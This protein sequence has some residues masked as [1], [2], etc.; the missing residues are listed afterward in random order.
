M[1]RC[2]AAHDLL[3]KTVQEKDVNII[4]GQEPNKSLCNRFIC[5]TNCDS[6]IYINRADAVIS[7]R[8]GSGYVF[9][10]LAS[11][12]VCSFYFSPN[13]DAAKFEELLS[14]VNAVAGSFQKETLFGGLFDWI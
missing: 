14:N 13:G 1:N 8:R 2:R 6:F 9:V 3:F 7:T 12:C 11:F 10:E 5:D 4:L